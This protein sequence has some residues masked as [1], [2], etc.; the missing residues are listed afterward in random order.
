MILESSNP[1]VLQDN[2]YDVVQGYLPEKLDQSDVDEINDL[3][4]KLQA[5][6]INTDDIVKSSTP[7][8]LQIVLDTLMHELRTK[9][10][11]AKLWLAYIRYIDML[12]LFIYAER[13]GN[14]N[15]HLV[16]V[17]WMLDLFAAARHF[18]YAK[19]AQLYLQWMLG[20]PEEHSWLP[21]QF[22]EYGFLSV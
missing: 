7:M 18:N 4:N 8:K 11:T 15:L 12:K 13:T 6:E 2:F 19:S 1:D 10:R 3:Y 9:S 22:S 21:Q 5:Y 20:L 14:W 16:E 17:G